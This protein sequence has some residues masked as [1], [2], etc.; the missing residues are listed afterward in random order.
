[1]KKF[2]IILGL[3]LVFQTADIKAQETDTDVVNFIAT[4][5]TVLNLNVTG[6]QNQ[7]VLFDTPDKYNLGVDV[8]GLT[9]I[10]IESIDAWDLQINAGNFSDGASASIPINNLG[11]W[12]EAT[13][14]H[15]IGTEVSCSNTDLASSMGIT[16]AD[17]TGEVIC[18]EYYSSTD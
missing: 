13:G 17:Q 7:T 11:V 1:M 14:A 12:C 6:G 3:L 15:L 2:T 10:T 9:T 8:V 18:Y 4:L 16:V 5:Q